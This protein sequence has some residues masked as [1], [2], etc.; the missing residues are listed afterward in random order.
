MAMIGITLAAHAASLPLAGAAEERS[1]ADVLKASEVRAGMAVVAGFK[2]PK[3]AID[4]AATG[5]FAVLALAPSAS[6][7]SSWREAVADAR[8]TGAVFVEDAGELPSLPCWNDQVDLVVLDTEALAATSPDERELHRVLGPQGV[9][10]LLRQGGLAKIVEP[11]DPRLGDWG[12]DFCNP[13]RNPVSRD[14]AAGIPTGLRWISGVRGR[15]GT[16]YMRIDG[17][18]VASM[19]MLRTQP[20]G[21][22]A[23]SRRMEADGAFSA[24]LA[25][26]GVPLWNSLDS[27]LHHRGTTGGKDQNLIASE[28]ELL[29][30]NIQGSAKLVALDLKTG[31]K[32][33]TYDKLPDMPDG[34]ESR[35]TVGHGKIIVANGREL[36]VADRQTGEVLWRRETTDAD[37]FWFQPAITERV[38]AVV[39]GTIER[40]PGGRRRFH[41]ESRYRTY[42]C[43]AVLALDLAT[44]K[45][46]WRWKNPGH[47]TE[48]NFRE[49]CQLF[50]AGNAVFVFRTSGQSGNTNDVY[51][52]ACIELTDGKQRWRIEPEGMVPHPRQPGRF[53]TVHGAVYKMAVLHDQVFLLGSHQQVRSVKTG[54][55]LRAATPSNTQCPGPAFSQKLVARGHGYY[56]DPTDPELKVSQ[57]WIVR[58]PCASLTYIARGMTLYEPSNCSCNRMLY[59]EIALHSDPHPAAAPDNMRLESSGHVP[60][61]RAAHPEDWPTFLGNHQR[62]ND[63]ATRLPEKLK[64]KWQRQ[65]AAVPSP[66]NPLLR[67]FML[68]GHWNGPITAPVVADGRVLLADSLQG[69]VKSLDAASGV[70]RWSHAIG[71]KIDAPPTWHAGAGYVGADDGRVVC[72]DA[73][74]GKLVWSYLLARSRRAIIAHGR[75]ASAWPVQGGV[76]AVDESI[77]A[78]AGWH[79][80]ADGGVRVAC[81]HAADG[82]VAWVREIGPT[83]HRQP[84]PFGKGGYHATT[85][86]GGTPFVAGEGLVGIPGVVLRAQD[87]EPTEFFYRKAIGYSHGNRRVDSQDQTG[88][89]W[90]IDFTNRIPTVNHFANHARGTGD[91]MPVAMFRGAEKQWTDGSGLIAA[92][93]T[94]AAGVHVGHAVSVRACQW[95]HGDLV[96]KP[97]WNVDLAGLFPLAL[98]IAGDEVVVAGFTSPPQSAARPYEPLPGALV[99]FRL[100]DGE[101]IER[102]ELPCAP[103]QH[104][105][106]AARGELFLA[107]QDGTIVC[108]GR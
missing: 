47:P 105:L 26:N 90:L 4:L 51:W 28:G 81:F 39:Q 7:R 23:F 103:V 75:P 107:G 57:N 106:A 86:Q 73:D 33:R 82:K 6:D 8:L 102:I 45:E 43:G 40:E 12:H 80:E 52:L 34:W 1:A 48:P 74:N 98:L 89:P 49:F 79:Q 64:V 60:Q 94:H 11:D 38:L 97:A 21:S 76:L 22:R 66:D 71:V 37:T 70:V 14:S 54:E 55:I 78:S 9:A 65:V 16:G 46:L 91:R 104:G 99:R 88:A 35:V 87:G 59:G 67:E 2:S 5:R 13:D 32:L 18:I 10:C 24:R 77:Y 100:A 92:S 95:G 108:L 53:Q 63:V 44:G 62:S 41:P 17:P 25:H 50:I 61:A 20:L 93:E 19:A 68:S 84:K 29:T 3:L 72:F 30:T 85:V 15:V 69:V 31:V 96:H 56:W 58:G 36:L 42:P 101:M 83:E 27:D